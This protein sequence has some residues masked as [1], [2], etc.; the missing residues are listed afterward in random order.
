M[1]NTYIG[2]MRKKISNIRKDILVKKYMN[3]KV[4]ISRL[5]IG[6]FKCFFRIYHKKPKLTIFVIMS[7][8]S[9]YQKDFFSNSLIRFYLLLNSPIFVSYQNNVPDRILSYSLILFI[10]V[11]IFF[12]DAFEPRKS[13]TG[14]PMKGI[15]VNEYV[16]TL[17]NVIPNTAK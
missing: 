13:K 17:E 6:T 8:D 3:L 14:K 7:Q 11:H 5:I 9:A 2:R 4:Y 15:K 12:D 10:T 16:K 1:I